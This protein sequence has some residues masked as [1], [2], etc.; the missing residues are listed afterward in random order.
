[1]KEMCVWGKGVEHTHHVEV[2]KLERRVQVDGAPYFLGVLVV[3]VAAVGVGQ[4]RVGRLLG[5]VLLF[6]HL[7]PGI[8]ILVGIDSLPHE[9]T[10]LLRLYPEEFPGEMLETLQTRLEEVLGEGGET[11]P[12]ELQLILEHEVLANGEG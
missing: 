9:Q 5:S 10:E 2:V 12:Q 6:I 7:L 3:L 1:M 11:L 8:H 4:L